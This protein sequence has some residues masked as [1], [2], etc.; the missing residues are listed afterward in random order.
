ML[1]L[2]VNSPVPGVA[3]A[4]V[5]LI[6]ICFLKASGYCLNMKKEGVID[7]NCLDL[8]TWDVGG[9]DVPPK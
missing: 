5:Y 6:F 4:A 7:L 8:A 1:T 3:L 2:N 9:S